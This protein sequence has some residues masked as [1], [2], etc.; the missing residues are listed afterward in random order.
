VSD[1]TS[2]KKSILI[3]AGEMSGDQHASKV[4][5]AMLRHSPDIKFWGL[6]G[7]QMLI[8]GMD[9]LYSVE[10][11]SVTG[12]VEVIK[13]L[14]FFKEVMNAVVSRCERE[15]PDAAILL[16]YPGFNMRL[17]KKLH[18]MG[19]PVYYYI[20]P[21]VWAWR[22]GRIDTIRK[23]VR[24]MFV[25]FPFEEKI[26]TE[27]GVPAEFVG[28]PLVEEL[29]DLM[30]KAAFFQENDLDPDRPLVGILPGSRSNEVSRLLPPLVDAVTIVNGTLPEVQFAVAKVK[31]LPDSLYAQLENFPDVRVISDHPYEIMAYSDAAIVASGTAT[32]ETAVLGTPLVVIY[33]VSPLSYLLARLLVEVD[34]IAMPNLVYGDRVVP[35]LLQNQANGPAIASWILTYLTDDQ[36]TAGV[37]T[38]L[39]TIREKLGDPGGAERIAISILNDL[40]ATLH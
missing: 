32:L 33:K 6:G 4:M 25:I 30:S 29:P 11:L 3:V 35:E 10:R 15:K 38:K 22:S 27:R 23:F 21:Q 8:V 19:I 13:H 31:H 12:F 9:Q 39:H 36:Y 2:I 24:K 34:H 18:A 26:Y 20:S 5:A 40:G 1:K 16:D 37:K 14:S 7:E 17:G 28:H